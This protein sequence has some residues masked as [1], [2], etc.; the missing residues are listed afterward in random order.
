[1]PRRESA[2]FI[3]SNQVETGL[4]N[5]KILL[6]LLLL[7]TYYNSVSYSTPES[8]GAKPNFPLHDCV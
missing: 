5:L 4:D 2:L 8:E 1:M 7:C 3:C 6:L